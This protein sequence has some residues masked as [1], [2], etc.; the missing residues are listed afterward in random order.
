MGNNDKRF[1]G[2]R[3]PFVRKKIS[4]SREHE[5]KAFLGTRGLINGEQEIKSKKMKGSWER[6]PHW[7]ELFIPRWRID[8][9]T[10]GTGRFPLVYETPLIHRWGN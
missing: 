2:S 8:R 7:E 3:E 5:R 10:L 1:C 9:G 4:G 6:A